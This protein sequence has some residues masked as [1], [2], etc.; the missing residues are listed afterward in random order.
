LEQLGIQNLNTTIE[1]YSNTALLGGTQAETGSYTSLDADGNP[2]TS[3]M[4]DVNLRQDPF[5]SQ[6]T[7]TI[8][9]PEELQVLPDL[10]GMGRLRS[11]QEAAALSPA[12]ADVLSRYA[13]AETRTEQRALL[14]QVLLE[15]AKTDPQY[16]ENP[17]RVWHSSTGGLSY[18]ENSSNVIYLRR[19]QSTTVVLPSFADELLVQRARTLDAAMGR[20]PTTTLNQGVASQI[21]GTNKAYNA[22]ADT[23]YLSLLTQTRLKKYLDSVELAVTDNSI[24]LDV[25]GI[26]AMFQDKITADPVNGLTDLIEFNKVAADFLFGTQWDGYAILEETLRNLT[27]T[28]ELQEVFTTF[29]VRFNGALGTADGDI[30]LGN[31]VNR[32][33]SG[34]DGDDVLLGG[35]GNE[36]IAGGNGNDVITGGSGNDHLRGEAGDDIYIFRRGNGNDNI[37]DTQGTNSILFSG[38]TPEEVTVTANCYDNLTF[39]I[40][41]TGETLTVESTSWYI[42]NFQIAYGNPIDL[43]I[44]SDGTVWDKDEALR[45]SVIRPTD[46][47][48]TIVGSSIDDIIMGLG[49]NDTITGGRG[50]DTIDG[51]TG[52]DTLQDKAGDDIYIFGRGYGHDV[53]NDYNAEENL[54]VM[55][56]KDDITPDEIS[57]VRDGNDLVLKIT[58][59]EDSVTVKNYFYDGYASESPHQYEIER[60]EFQD[61]TIWT[62]SF[63]RDLLLAGSDSSET[64]IG[65]RVDDFITGQDGDDVIEARAG[66][67][68]IEGGNGNDIIHAG[69]GRDIIDGGA[70]DDYLDGNVSRY[71]YRGDG[72][73]LNDNDTYLFGFGSGHDTIRDFGWHDGNIDVIRFSEGITS[74]TVR[75]ERAGKWSDDLKIIVGDGSDTITIKDWF[76]NNADYHKIERLEFADGATIESSYIDA[77]L[78]VQG[79]SSN[80]TLYGTRSSETLTGLEGSDT[81]FGYYGNDTLDGGSGDDLLQG[82]YGADT[83]IFGKNYGRDTI[84]EGFD[85]HHIDY[86]PNDAI[87]FTPDVIPE[88]VIIRRSGNNMVLSINGTEDRLTVINGFGENG[89]TNHIE[90]VRFADGTIWDY[91]TMQTRA[92]LATE[93]D[94]VIEGTS[95]SDILDGSTGNDLLIGNSGGDTYRFDRSYGQDVIQDNGWSW[96]GQDTIHFQEGITAND[97]SFTI[98]DGDLLISIKDTQDS[99]RIKNGTNVIEQFV[100]HDGTTLTASDIQGIVTFPPDSETLVGTTGDD[101][102]TGS[103]LDGVLLG[104]QGNDVLNGFGGADTL[105]GAEGDDILNGGTG[106]DTLIGGTGANIYRFERGTGLDTMISRP[107]D[108]MDDTIEF[109][110]GITPSDI[111]VQLG[112]PLYGE[113]QPGDT[114]FS[115]LVIG[116]GNNDACV[117]TV[118]D[119]GD[120]SKS[121]VRKFRFSD[122]TDMTLEQMLALND[123]GVAG[124]QR[125][126]DSDDILTG[127]DG[128]DIIKGFNGNDSLRGRDNNDFISGGYGNDLISADA[129]TDQ[130]QGDAGNDVLA[131]G[132]GDDQLDG[133]TGNDTYVFNRGAGN[134]HICASSNPDQTDTLSF[135]VGIG[136]Q[137]ITAYRNTDGEVVLLVDSGSGGSITLPWFKTDSLYESE[138]LPIH[139][140]Q[141]V[142]SDGRV[143]AYDFKTLIQ[144]KKGILASSDIT[145]PVALFDEADS[146]DISQKV[147]PGGGDFAISY[148]QNGDLFGTA[149][150]TGV[151]ETTDGDDILLGSPGMDTLNGGAGNDL[152]IGYTGDDYLEGAEGN[153]RIDAGSGDDTL[154]GGEGN[155]ALFGGDGDDI[156]FSGSGNDIA[157]G[158]N[159]NDT[160]I[161]NAGDGNLTIEDSCT[162]YR[163]DDSY[164]DGDGYGGDYGGDYG[165]GFI[166]ISAINALQFGPGISFDD[167]RFSE[168]EG[169][170]VIDIPA[171]GDQ[172]RLAGYDGGRQ[173]FN[174]AV[175]VF[176][177][178]DG[179]EV[180]RDDILNK[181]ITVTG[182]GEDDCFYGTEGA[183]FIQGGQG[184]DT[185]DT[186]Y[187][188][189]RLQGDSGND[190]YIFNKGDGIDT[191]IDISGSEMGNSIRFGYG[192]S[193]DDL[194]AVVEDG[195]LVVRV[196]ENGDALRFEGFD[197][198]ITVMPQP[199]TEFNFDDGT[200]FSFDDFLAMGYEIVGTPQADNLWGTPEADSIRGLGDNDVLYGGAGDDFYIFEPGD[201]TD[202]IDDLS[203]P[204]EENTILLPEGSDPDNVFLSHDPDSDILILRELGTDNEIRLSHFNRLDPFG[205]RAVEFFQFG[206][207]GPTLSYDEL[208]ARGFDIIGSDDND[209][210]IGTSTTDRIYGG[211]GDDLLT[212]GTGND[213]LYG[214][215]GDDTYI[216]NQG[217]GILNI[218]DTVEPGAG[219]TLLFG[220][221]IL[222]SDLNRHIRFEPP[223]DG[224]EGSLVI[225]FD[226]GDMIRLAGFDP[227]DV[228]NSSRSVETFQFDDGTTLSFSELARSIFVVEGDA[229]DNELT[230]TNLSDRLYGYQGDDILY[231]GQGD[232]VLTGGSDDDTLIGGA[233]MDSYILNLGD[234]TDI[235]ID[236][237]EDGI[238]NLISFGEG[239]TRESL[240]LVQDGDNL[241]IQY[242]DMGDQVTIESFYPQSEDGA[243][244]I[245]AFEFFDGGVVSYHELTNH[246]PKE[247]E[248]ILADLTTNEDET[249]TFQVPENAFM[250]EDGDPLTYSA[251]TLDG[252]PL[253]SWLIFDSDTMTF[254]GIPE[255]GS[256]GDL[257][258]RVTATDGYGA[259]A[260]DVFHLDIAPAPGETI[261]GAD[262]NDTLTGTDGND[263]L[264][265][266][267]GTDVLS[268][269]AG[270]DT[271][272]FS[273]DTRAAWYEMAV[274]AGNLAIEMISGKNLSHDTYDGGEGYDELTATEADDA[275]FLDRGLW[276]GPRITDIESIAVGAGNDLVDLTSFRYGYGDVVIDGGAGNDVLWANADNDVLFGGSGNDKLDGGAGFDIL[277]GGTDSDRLQGGRNADLLDGGAENDV[278]LG[279]S[280]ND[281]ILCGSGDDTI[282]TGSGQDIIAFNRGDGRDTVI[283]S[284]DGA[285]AITLGGGISLDD[286]SFSKSGSD[287]VFETGA[288]EAIVLKGWYSSSLNRDVLTL[289]LVQEA[290]DDFD[291]S[292]E[293][294]LLDHTIETFDFAGLVSEFDQARSADP[295]LTAWELSNALSQF[296][297]G[298]SDTEALGGDLSYRYGL[299]GT[300]SGMGAASARNILADPAFGAT[301]QALKPASGLQ[302]GMVKLG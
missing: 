278:L 236:A 14:D 85:E 93:G 155:D 40:N 8:D 140:V 50:N 297:L 277:Q 186:G 249:F 298:G 123:G 154:S 121:S 2:I 80:D 43:I 280:G 265:G 76:A 182:T 248:G 169:Y 77:H 107:V 122:D 141:F 110:A 95:S 245:D 135:G 199:V 25:S 59:T 124:F 254:S 242:G 6:Y 55:K 16:T 292:S 241:K 74:D 99:L 173:T 137:D 162:E 267:T 113:L 136:L 103:D 66:N 132:T 24:N 17:I 178:S 209:T 224:M 62:A 148:A 118:D 229:D 72:D 181:G 223:Q 73:H 170:L 192:I 293:N 185:F 205:E 250:D 217:D 208:L 289:Q 160:Y 275:V 128:D 49:G 131:G 203:A 174:S 271:L 78:V 34:A 87:Q 70:G 119:G 145:Y 294:T 26:T 152:I 273:A 46:G 270:D 281:F 202:T 81:L 143:R 153:D 116:I 38:L 150:Y 142:D 290:S 82:E 197:P 218:I 300:L 79:T 45:Q 230:G 260:A 200:T 13:T 232:D 211:D 61:G 64:I 163:Y 28:P 29:N 41:D 120:I 180:T 184:D 126:T 268:A 130:L 222:P 183:D 235:I 75:F 256:A 91:A 112:E 30:T 71:N 239:I 284:G 252:D 257:D 194:K 22:L 53:I 35:S 206:E 19:G 231:A 234:G 189:D 240:T 92:L 147:L 12:L 33:I 127:S 32:T 251:A 51:G 7:D 225:L 171:T 102:L 60:I 288:G 253:P 191:I 27:V 156:L 159:G 4:A 261:I 18:D 138:T 48:D 115:R 133:G 101:T 96:Q 104:L 285:D 164:D 83:Y 89:D 238:G 295:S 283:S 88:D 220:P 67:D 58:G 244:I 177:F 106:R 151:N 175:D 158:G 291:A 198:R 165:G 302:E 23:I 210:L 215:A 86:S 11:L 172:V 188:N 161:F 286:L 63:F 111:R 56:F 44:F 219:N 213:T 167:L 47:D 266:G 98:D 114:G 21:S 226:N 216:F 97:L 176:R 168:Q 146:Y 212:G 221:G 201:C 108:G 139:V 100:F 10:P 37:K 296:H 3:L 301:L 279:G 299:D 190:T 36:T 237:V 263:I 15:W 149:N 233:G 255:K 68:T 65:Y 1:S 20:T 109:G 94:D 54:D 243:T 52:N 272:I 134:D 282:Y 105:N 246:P 204:D 214:E 196:G 84:D 276:N 269:G 227:D 258:I 57:V 90:E 144:D 274:N 9:V 166:T 287:L 157:W 31:E 228:D 117:V 207:N 247:G 195:T 5:Y 179:N 187:G 125:G 264:D 262:G 193:T 129:G 259:S 39:R 69:Y 42:D